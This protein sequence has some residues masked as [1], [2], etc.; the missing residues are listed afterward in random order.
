[1]IGV[2]LVEQMISLFSLFSWARSVLEGNAEGDVTIFD[3]IGVRRRL[4]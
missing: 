3:V 4:K 2:P 1:M